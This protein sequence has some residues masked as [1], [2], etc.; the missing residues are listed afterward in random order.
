MRKVAIMQPYFMPY[1]G[2][3]QL[4]NAVD[5]FIILDDVN[6]INKGWINRNNILVANKPYLFTV[7]LKDASQNKLIYEIELLQDGK[8]QKKLLKTI[9]QAYKK[10]P[11]YAEVFLLF[12]SILNSTEKNLSKFIYNS[13]QIIC[14]YLTINTLIIESSNIFEN[15][16]QLKA[17]DRI[18]DICLQKNAE[19]YI[20]PIGGTEL[21]DK[22]HFEKNNIQLNFLKTNSISYSQF[23]NEFIPYLSIL[24]A[25]MFVEKQELKA[26]LNQYQLQ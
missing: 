17:E 12:E 18:I 2:Y 1:I 26:I 4:I 14:K 5:E 7:P 13:L 6:Y 21:Y 10:A 25:L 24:D 11:F 23:S 22:T 16:Y 9:E 15:K 19:Q 20:N 8:W 3:F